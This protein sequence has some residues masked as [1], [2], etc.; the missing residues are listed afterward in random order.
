MKTIIQLVLAGSVFATLSSFAQLQPGDYWLQLQ[1][2][3]A[4][5]WDIDHDG[6]G[7]S[8]RYEYYAGTDPYS[9]SNALSFVMSVETNQARFTWPSALHARYRVVESPTLPVQMWSPSAAAPVIGDASPLEVWLSPLLPPQ[10]FYVI[11]PMLPLNSDPD[12]LSDREEAILGTRIDLADT[13][14]DTMNDDVEVLQTGTDPLVFDPLGGTIEGKVFLDDS[15]DG[16]VAGDPPLENIRVFLDTNFNGE[17]DPGE[18]WLFTAADGSYR[19]ANLAPGLYEV[20]QVLGPGVSQTLPAQ[21]VPEVMDG[22]PDELLNYTHAAGGALPEAYGYLRQDPWPGMQFVILGSRIEAVEPAVVLQ[23]FG[24]RLDFPPIGSYD[25][26]EYLSMPADASVTI[27]FDEGLVDL[28]GPDFLLGIPQQGNNGEQYDLFAGPDVSNLTQIDNSANQLNSGLELAPI[29]LADSGI[30]GPVHVLRF[31]SRT[32]GGVGEGG[33][34]RGAALGGVQALHWVP[35]QTDARRVQIVGNETVSDQDFGRHEQDNPPTLL[36]SNPV[37][38]PRAGQAYTFQL[39]ASD[40]I[41]VAATSLEINGQPVAVGSDGTVSYTP[42]YPGRLVL[43]GM[44]TDTGGNVTSQD[45]SLF[46]NNPDG[47]LP[48]DPATIGD[49]TVGDV[50]I[51]I[52][53]P[54]AGS[55]LATNTAIIGEITSA[56]GAPDW[57]ISYAPIGLVD[58]NDL[59]TPDAD[60]IPLASGS[61]EVYSEPLATFPAGSLADGIYFVRIAA[62]PANGGATVYQGHVLGINVAPADLRPQIV[63][64]SP[65]NG[66]YATLVQD[67]TGSIVSGRP[68]TEWTVD[69]ARR[70]E[71]DLNDLGAS[72]PDWQTINAGVGTVSTAIVASIDT[73]LLRNDSYIVRVTAWNDLRLGRVEGLVLEVSNPAKLGRHRREFVDF[74]LNLA[75]FPLQI[76]RIYDSFE[77]DTV[78]DFGYGWQFGFADPDL[79]ETLPD[80]GDDIFSATSYRDGTRV[81]LTAPD[82]RRI[83]FTFRAEFVSATL[84]GGLYRAT[85]EPDP[86]VN[87][88]LEVPE[89]DTGFLALQPNG[90]VRLTFIGFAWN[91]DV[92]ILTMPDGKRYTY[93]QREGLV[94][95]EDPSGNTITFSD[96]G[97][98][99]SGGQSLVFARDAAGRIQ[100]ITLPTGES[101]QY[102]YDAAGDLDSMIDT[103]GYQTSFGYHPTL[104]HYLTT[105]TDP[106]GRV[107]SSYEYDADGRLSA[108][109]DPLGNRTLQQ[110]DPSS[111]TGS[112]TDGNSNTT[113]LVYDERGNVLQE[114]DAAGDVVIYRYDDPRHPD[115]ETEIEA[116]GQ[117]TDIEYNDRGQSTRTRVN[118]TAVVISDYDAAGDLIEFSDPSVDR[119]TLAYDSRGLA[120]NVGTIIDRDRVANTYTEQGLLESTAAGGAAFLRSYDPASGQLR[121]ETGPSGY[122]TTTAY[123]SF[124]NATSQTNALGH[125]TRTTFEP[126]GVVTEVVD[127]RGETQTQN[128]GAGGNLTA[129][130]K[131]GAG[132]AFEVDANGDPRSVSLADGTLIQPV[133]DGNDNIVAMPI[134]GGAT[135][136]FGYDHDNRMTSE[137]DAAGRQIIR[138]Y[139]AI[140]Q[141]TNIVDRNGKRRGFTY[142]A[143]GFPDL[144]TW[145][146]SAGEVLRQFDFDF[147][148]RANAF[149]SVTD[150]SNTWTFSHLAGHVEEY[151]RSSVVYGGQAEFRMLYDWVPGAIGIPRRIRIQDEA[152]SV[153]TDGA[154]D[155]TF[156]GGRL[157]EMN[158]TVR[159]L[160]S[161][162]DNQHVRFHYDAMGRNHRIERYDT[163][164]TSDRNLEPV[165]VTTQTFNEVNQLV[166]LRHLTGTGTLAFAESDFAFQRSALGRIREIIQP[167]NTSLYGYDVIGQLTSAVHSVYAAEGFAFDAA[168]NPAG[169]LVGSGN[170]LLSDGAFQAAYDHEG[171]MT[172]LV[173][174]A[175]GTITTFAYDHLNLLNLVQRQTGPGAAP[176]TL[177]RFASDWAGRTM[178]QEIGGEKRWMLYDRNHVFATFRDGEADI[179]QQRFYALNDPDRLMGEWTEE[180]GVHWFLT[181]HLGSVRGVVDRNGA[182]VGWV[183]YD[184]SGRV[185]GALP[186]GF[187]ELRFAGRQ[188]LDALGLYQNGFRYYHPGTR[189]FT[190]QDPLR[191]RSGDLNFYRYAGN[192]PISGTDPTGTTSAL[193]YSAFFADIANQSATY[194]DIGKCVAGLIF[195]PNQGL[196][197]GQGQ[198]PP[199]DITCLKNLTGILGGP[200]GGPLLNGISVPGNDGPVYIY[201][202]PFSPPGPNYLDLAG[203]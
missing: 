9:A 158:W 198:P 10:Q 32:P 173:E 74:D 66:S 115:L 199:G 184:S 117:L 152:D 169:S 132:T 197:G 174:I 61:G 26:A 116:A 119:R 165:S 193:E 75:G 160:T 56:A 183:D 150:G 69:L 176:V 48:F 34:D 72:D 131:D 163:R 86:G 164:S 62:Q 103:E 99:H 16:A 128:L 101:W 54:E 127:P 41:G 142:D 177:A 52:F 93:D 166:G 191:H 21:V 35:P 45:W 53:T 39:L 144:E 156:I 189:R 168:G 180:N 3:A 140:G 175:T 68:I 107:G 91:P 122:R 203:F 171:N 195:N 55:N 112:V 96:E 83:G 81:Y 100:T 38:D 181:D 162:A 94:G 76:L 95:A 149:R 153:I 157:Y 148:G 98:S 23:P 27:R 29:D 192:N 108:I 147:G 44:V 14:G 111:F 124:G 2:L 120:T 159:D 179:S 80:T 6:D 145:Y 105:I 36:L 187:G 178:F 84:L 78:G 87:A 4:W 202:G 70:S 151:N 12:A 20:R 82:G 51:R 5:E 73:S 92:F 58:P 19:F 17:E 47:T 33:A 8:S 170:R 79:R 129:A 57:S 13:D 125:V 85:F 143:A 42:V 50:S 49:G 146:G 37:S 88:T 133:Y 185:R 123:D 155:S 104:P 46:V 7:I 196:V 118:G 18:P 188:S 40:D 106:F 134:L 201:R 11:E 113:Q 60:Y 102:F 154:V 67:V 135:S 65:T 126:N 138:E 30:S 97:V 194:A 190:Q 64:H 136:V 90:E 59:A 200:I 172:S 186:T 1:G 121:T 139:N 182:P 130:D 109:V 24:N 31:V 167:H 43:E 141:V 161:L 137:T 114:T 63:F 15:R 25:T 22:W 28:P 110:F 89:G 71:V 77:T